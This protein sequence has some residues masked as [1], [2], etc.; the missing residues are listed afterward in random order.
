MIVSWNSTVLT[1]V[2]EFVNPS[3]AYLTDTRGQRLGGCQKGGALAVFIISDH[4]LIGRGGGGA[5]EVWRAE[6]CFVIR[7]SG[8]EAYLA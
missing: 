1:G 8:R 4:V 7:H 2:S 5:G 3:A 6:E